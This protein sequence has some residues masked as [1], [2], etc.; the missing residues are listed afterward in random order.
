[1]TMNVLDDADVTHIFKGKG[2]LVFTIYEG[3]QYLPVNAET[4]EKNPVKKNLIIIKN[5]GNEQIAYYAPEI[6]QVFSCYD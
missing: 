2:K 1:M 5:S 4:R 3:S 6:P